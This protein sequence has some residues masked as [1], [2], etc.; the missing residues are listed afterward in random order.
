MI[1]KLGLSVDKITELGYLLFLNTALPCL[2]AAICFY[3][4]AEPYSILKLKIEEEKKEA[5]DLAEKS[6]IELRSN[7]I[8]AIIKLKLSERHLTNFE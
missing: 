5:L 8:E 6:R 2:L 3:K 7:S 4:S 1:T